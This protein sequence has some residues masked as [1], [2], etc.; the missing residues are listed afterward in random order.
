MSPNIVRTRDPRAGNYNSGKVNQLVRLVPGQ[1]PSQTR[2]QLVQTRKPLSNATAAHHTQRKRRHATLINQST[3]C[4]PPQ[5][6]RSHYCP[7]A[8]SWRIA[9]TAAA[10]C[11]GRPAPAAAASSS[12]CRYARGASHTLG[13]AGRRPSSLSFGVRGE[14]ERSILTCSRCSCLSTPA[15]LPLP[16]PPSASAARAAPA[17]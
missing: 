3:I 2:S 11:G 13:R 4:L 7:P 17:G 15:D 6:S 14:K 16:K 1:S 8:S 12:S 9:E 10:T 5:A